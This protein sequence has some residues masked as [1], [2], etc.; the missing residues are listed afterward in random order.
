[1]LPELAGITDDYAWLE[2]QD[3]VA[4]D[5]DFARHVVSGRNADRAVTRRQQIAKNFRVV[6]RS[7]PHES[8]ALSIDSFGRLDMEISRREFSLDCPDLVGIRC[9]NFYPVWVRAAWGARD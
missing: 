5:A 4:G 9:G 1:M 3:C 6:G 7:I 8:K 2:D